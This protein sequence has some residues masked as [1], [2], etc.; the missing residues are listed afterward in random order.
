MLNSYK[1]VTSHFNGSVLIFPSTTF[2]YSIG[3]ARRP[4]FADRGY[5]DDVHPI[6]TFANGVSTT[7]PSVAGK[8]FQV[9]PAIDQAWSG[10]PQTPFSAGLL[11]GMF[12]GSVRTVSPTVDATIFWGA[13]T[14]NGGEVLGDW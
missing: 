10:I 14:P 8:T 4:G 9:R 11:V 7:R 3:G 6:T 1:V 13:V 2:P 12:D 5:R